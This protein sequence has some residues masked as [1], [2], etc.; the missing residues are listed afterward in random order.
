VMHKAFVKVDET[1]T[2]AAAATAVI[3]NLTAMPEPPVEMNINR[4][5]LF[6]IFDTETDAIIFMGRVMDPGA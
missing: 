6:F 2:E 1:G 3:M 4:P 5:F